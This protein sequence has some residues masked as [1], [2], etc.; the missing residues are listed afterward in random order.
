MTISNLPG[1]LLVVLVPLWLVFVVY[2]RRLRTKAVNEA[3]EQLLRVIRPRV[4]RWRRWSMSVFALSSV[5]LVM[6]WAL[7]LAGPAEGG[8]SSAELISN[9]ILLSLFFGLFYSSTLRVTY[10]DFRRHGIVFGA[11]S[12]WPWD[13][14][15]GYAWLDGGPT[16]RLRIAGHGLTDYRI[17]FAQKEAVDRLLR[18]KLPAADNGVGTFPAPQGTARR[19]VNMP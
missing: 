5:V 3:S 15:H 1:W 12:F 14:V 10:I 18:A 7:L 13:K 6:R 16:L 8:H 2:V 17:D 4:T 9:T 19:A 11:A